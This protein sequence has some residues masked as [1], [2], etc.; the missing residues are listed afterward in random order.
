MLRCCKQSDGGKTLLLILPHL[1]FQ[2]LAEFSPCPWPGQ[3]A[4]CPPCSVGY[5]GAWRLESLPLAFGLSRN[6]LIGEI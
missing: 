6:R 5:Q 4:F 2:T 1:P 3:P